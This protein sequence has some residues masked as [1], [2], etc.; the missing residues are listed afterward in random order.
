MSVLGRLARL[1]VNE[2]RSNI[3][4]L[5]VDEGLP[6]RG[7]RYGGDGTVHNTGTIDVVIEDGVV[8]EV[9]FRCRQLRAKVSAPKGHPVYEVPG[10]EDVVAVETVQ[11]CGKCGKPVT[12]STG[13]PVDYADS[14]P[15]MHV[16][17]VAYTNHPCGCARIQPVTR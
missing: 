1:T 3:D 13:T 2:R 14:G 12:G 9:W 16:T 8:T 17:A 6:A 10:G 11:R 4:R 15:Y 7:E 5:T